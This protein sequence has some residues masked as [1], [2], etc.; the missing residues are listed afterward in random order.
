MNDEFTKAGAGA[1]VGKTFEI[2]LEYAGL[3]KGTRGLVIGADKMGE[4]YSLVIQWELQVRIF[5]TRLL[6]LRYWMT[7]GDVQRFLQE[8]QP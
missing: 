1:L 7:K 3:P 4:G 5:K 6:P 2:L 8:V